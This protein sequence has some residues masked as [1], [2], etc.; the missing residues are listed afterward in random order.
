VPR[1]STES[2]PR[3]RR[4]TRSRPRRCDCTIRSRTAL[5][6][7]SSITVVP[8]RPRRTVSITTIIA[9]RPVL[10]NACW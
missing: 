7:W 10:G 2:P 8:S 3:S 4:T 5:T 9:A 6:R 1:P